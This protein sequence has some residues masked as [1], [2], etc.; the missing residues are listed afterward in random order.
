MFEENVGK[1]KHYLL[2][3]ANI[4]VIKRC[5]VLVE[6]FDAVFAISAFGVVLAVVT[7]ST[8]PVSGCRKEAGIEVTFFS[9]V[10]TVAF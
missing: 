2:T 5:A 9:M 7:D 3:L 6:A 4:R 8:S 1:L 10:V